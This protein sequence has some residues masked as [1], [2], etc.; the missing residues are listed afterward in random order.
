[1][2]DVTHVHSLRQRSPRTVPSPV[3]SHQELDSDSL[4]YCPARI[5]TIT[6][7]NIQKETTMDKGKVTSAKHH[8]R[9][10]TRSVK[11]RSRSSLIK[12]RPANTTPTSL[13]GVK[14]FSPRSNGNGNGEHESPPLIIHDITEGGLKA[15]THLLEQL[16]SDSGATLLLA[17]HLN[18]EHQRQLAGL[19]LEES[20]KEA[21][22]AIQNLRTAL[23]T[24]EESLQQRTIEAA[25]LGDELTNVLG[26][27]QEPL[28]VVG[29][30][31][32]V[33]LYSLAA[34]KVLNL[35]PDDIGRK[36][37]CIKLGVQI[38][39]LQ[40]IISNVIDASN[41]EQQEVVNDLGRWFLLSVYPYKTSEG[42]VD[43]AVLTFRDIDADKKNEA[44]LH[45][46]H[47]KEQCYHDIV[48]E[49][50]MIVDT[51]GIV[52]M[53]SKAGCELLGLDETTIIGKRWIDEFVPKNHW[54]VARTIFDQV[55]AGEYDKAYEYPIAANGGGERIISWRSALL[56]DQAGLVT[57]VI[58][59][60][61]DLTPFRQ[62]NTALQKSEER[63]HLM[64]ES[65]REDEFFIMDTEGYIA[66]WI[67][68]PEEGKSFCAA[69]MVGQ[70]FSRLYSSD[71]FQSGKP[72]R[73]LNIAESE[74][75]YEEDGW[76]VRRDGT[77]MRAL[78][79]IL[80]IRDESRN[81]LGYSNVTRYLREK[82]V[83]ET[84]APGFSVPL[85]HAERG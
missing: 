29:H 8:E 82:P 85:E 11:A 68:R 33:K 5:P 9:R 60:G 55:V 12:N 41:V 28:V 48:H 18:P 36:V 79:I 80:P 64:M 84:V 34:V 19:L 43:G 42:K 59:S 65:V 20:K 14:P 62:I 16:Q 38:P 76:R 24:S 78:V 2:V 70:H 50:L 46:C 74:G 31:L 53:M 61:E 44:F 4:T 47:V 37:T 51:R 63:F 17:H 23:A 57:G 69:E 58:C 26:A 83:R 49:I 39:N 54:T 75:R 22:E 21:A 10:H 77:R 6:M 71:D 27:I 72:M 56:K 13:V 73:I 32:R 66:S 35:N 40:T 25:R 7:F 1:M 67:A 30:D 81:L 52:M 15:F 3:I 45:E